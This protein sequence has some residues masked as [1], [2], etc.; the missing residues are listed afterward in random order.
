M[1]AIHDKDLVQNTSTD[2]KLKGTR[3]A[4]SVV[5]LLNSF[6][7]KLNDSQLLE[8]IQLCEKLAEA[9]S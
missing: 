1:T 9:K 4:V 5:G 7:Y 2:T 8:V 6:N 3:L